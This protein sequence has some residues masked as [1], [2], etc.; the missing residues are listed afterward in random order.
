[1][2]DN[3]KDGAIDTSAAEAFEKY[4]VPT[5]FGP[6][7]EAMIDHAGTKESHNLLDVGCGSGAAA[8]YAAKIVGLTGSVSAI[9]FN[10]GMITHART[11]DPVGQ[12]DWQQGDVTDMPYDDGVFDII[13]GNQL[14]QFLPEKEKGLSEMKRVL[15]DSGR[16]ALTVYCAP[17][18]NPAHAAVANA[19]EKHGID[20]KGVVHPFSYGDPVVLGDL[21]QDAGFRDVSVV[22]KQMD[23]Y[24]SS[25]ENFIDCLAAG[26]P[27]SRHALEQL[28]ADGLKGLKAE[29]TE[30]LA[31]FMDADK[32]L[33]VITAA[34]MALVRA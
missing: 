19:L 31:E 30:T 33:R 12:I 4:L 18:R 34:N 8:R 13:A 10:A 29:V 24:F 23:S 21:L 3:S 16:L 32:G 22:R 26:G 20:S 5:I 7:S 15:A 2:A 1:M 9:D 27:S 14:L 11:L 6:W 25:A 28:D 17:H